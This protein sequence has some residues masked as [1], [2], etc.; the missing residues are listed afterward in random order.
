MNKIDEKCATMGLL[1][2]INPAAEAQRNREAAAKQKVEALAK[3][4]ERLLRLQARRAVRAATGGEEA[5]TKELEQ[6]AAA[7]AFTAEEAALTEEQL[8]DQVLHLEEQLAMHTGSAATIAAA[9]AAAAGDVQ[10][11]ANAEQ[12]EAKKVFARGGRSRVW[13][14]F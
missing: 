11:V 5:L 4:K 12:L 14:A 8:R 13:V 6:Q 9:V 7:E 1:G 2:T 3:E 10:E